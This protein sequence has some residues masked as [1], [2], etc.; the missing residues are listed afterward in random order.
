MIEL[1]LQKREHFKRHFRRRR[2]K[3]HFRH[4]PTWG[5]L[6]LPWPSMVLPNPRPLHKRIYP[7]LSLT[8]LSPP[9]WL[10]GW[11]DGLIDRES[12]MLYRISCPL[13]S[14]PCYNSGTRYLVQGY[15]SAFHFL[16]SSISF[17]FSIPLSFILFSSIF[18]HLL[19]SFPKT[20]FY[21]TCYI[22]LSHR[23]K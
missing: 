23:K 6:S 12:T 11:M 2:K 8:W 16:S 13:G 5:S 9:A 1:S 19:T 14:L 21:C 7:F 18:L 3:R 4:R 17:S 22:I 15:L 20:V 10:V